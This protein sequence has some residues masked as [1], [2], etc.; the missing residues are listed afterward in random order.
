MTSDPGGKVVVLEPRF[1]LI[2]FDKM[3]VGSDLVYL[4][5]ASF[6]VAVSWWCGARRNAGNRSGSLT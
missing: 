1:R 5:K 3:T 2:P 6:P 4:V